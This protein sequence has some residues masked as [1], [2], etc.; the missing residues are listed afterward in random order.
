MRSTQDADDISYPSSARSG[1]R[2]AAHITASGARGFQNINDWDTTRILLKH[3]EEVAQT[4]ARI[5]K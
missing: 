4:M 2:V 3:K 1:I 5:C